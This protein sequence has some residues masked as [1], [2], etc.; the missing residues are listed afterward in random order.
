MPRGDDMVK[1]SILNVG[2]IMNEPR[3]MIM[4][5]LVGGGSV[6]LDWGEMADFIVL[7]GQER[8]QPHNTSTTVKTLGD[9]RQIGLAS[10]ISQADCD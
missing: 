4:G 7:S 1:R 6:T 2:V 5:P 9:G 10:D 3:R 8:L